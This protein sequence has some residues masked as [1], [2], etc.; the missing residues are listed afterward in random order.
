MSV[1]DRLF[2]IPFNG[3]A[4]PRAGAMCTVCRTLCTDNQCFRGHAGSD[5]EPDGFFI[6]DT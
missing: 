5:W 3:G 1:G 6:R 4:L 2:R